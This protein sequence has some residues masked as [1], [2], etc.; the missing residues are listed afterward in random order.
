VTGTDDRAAAIAAVDAACPRC[1]AYRER[2]QAYCLECGEALPRVTGSLPGLRRRWIRRFG[3]YPGDWI[4]PALVLLAVAAAGAAVAATVSH[5]R[6]T[7]THVVTAL[8]P[9][10]G[11]TA[12]ASAV[13]QQIWP[14]GETG[15]TVIL[16]SFPTATGKSE[17]D[18]TVAQAVKDGLPQVGVLDSSRSASLQPGYFVVFSGIYSSQGDANAAEP[19]ARQAGFE[20]SYTRQVAG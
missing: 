10:P 12:A 3:W 9:L 19:E 14:A 1:G 16:G 11:T 20:T 4:W 18:A 5:R 6:T 2:D 17:A 7:A 15:W 8:T 13:G